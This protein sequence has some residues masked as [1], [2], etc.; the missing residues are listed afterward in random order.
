MFTYRGRAQG[1]LIKVQGLECVDVIFEC[2]V[3][4]TCALTPNYFDFG[5]KEKENF[6]F[7]YKR[8][9]SVI[10]CVSDVYHALGGMCDV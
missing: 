4:K 1:G 5:K 7:Y 10:C 3:R 2:F 8:Q 9:A 6:Y